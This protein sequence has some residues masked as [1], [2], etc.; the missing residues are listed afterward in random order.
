MVVY[1]NSERGVLI[2]FPTR[3][4]LERVF[5]THVPMAVKVRAWP[6]NEIPADHFPDYDDVESAIEAL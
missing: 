1:Q 2:K 6:E 5:G 4:E 3:E